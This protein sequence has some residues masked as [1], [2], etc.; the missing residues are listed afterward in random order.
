[1][2]ITDFASSLKPTNLP[3]ND[4]DDFYYFFDASGRGVCNIAP[5]RFYEGGSETERLRQDL[6]G[7]LWS[8]DGQITEAMDV[9][10]AGCVIAE[11]FVEGGGTFRYDLSRLFMEGQRAKRRLTQIS[12]SFQV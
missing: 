12:G 1:V 10:S 6:E 9:F 5:E 3:L 8:K 7:D 2:Y 11:L 4:P